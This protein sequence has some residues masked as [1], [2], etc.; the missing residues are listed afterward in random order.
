M[1]LLN[2]DLLLSISLVIYVVGS[3][4]FAVLSLT[5]AAHAVQKHRRAQEYGSSEHLT[6]RAR[7]VLVSKRA[8][9][10]LVAVIAVPLIIFLWPPVVVY[11]FF[12]LL[13]RLVHDA[14]AGSR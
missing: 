7:D 9:E 13:I 10:A 8:R 6:E 11:S 4:I 1:D 12:T 14:K 3:S 5:H 2:R